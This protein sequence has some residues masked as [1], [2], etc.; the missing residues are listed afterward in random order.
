MSSI[1][2][3]CNNQLRST[4]I[5]WQP[6]TWQPTTTYNLGDIVR[7]PF[8]MYDRTYWSGWLY[9]CTQPGTSGSGMPTDPSNSTNPDWIRAAEGES[10]RLRG[11]QMKN[12]PSLKI[13]N[14]RHR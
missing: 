10:F 8:I 6:N 11:F 1:S 13:L 5:P 2:V 12:Q 7:A 3:I 4:P 14:I 9:E